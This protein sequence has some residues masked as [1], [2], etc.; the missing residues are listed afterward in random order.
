MYNIH[1]DFFKKQTLNIQLNVLS[2]IMY[3]GMLPKK[4]NKNLPTLQKPTM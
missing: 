1:T 2:Q 3:N 4:R